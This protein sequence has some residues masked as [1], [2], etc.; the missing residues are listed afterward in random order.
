[1][2]HVTRFLNDPTLFLHFYDYLPFEEDLGL[3]LYNFKFPLPEDD[4]LF[5]PSLIE[6]GLLVLEKR[7]FFDKHM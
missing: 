3:I 1:L 6:I 4:F 5:V 7:L 2:I